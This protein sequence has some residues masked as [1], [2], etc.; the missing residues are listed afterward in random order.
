MKLPQEVYA[1]I[2]SRLLHECRSM[3]SAQKEMQEL[4]AAYNRYVDL[5]RQME[6]CR[7]RMSTIMRLL[8]PKRV[9]DTIRTD[10]AAFLRQTLEM[11]PSLQEPRK[12]LKLWRA[13]REYL[14]VAGNSRVGDVQAFL[15]WLGIKNVTRQAI[16]SALRQHK[17]TFQ[18]S[19]TGRQRYVGLKK[20]RVFP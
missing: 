10:D 2:Q 4:A 20:R 13:V 8:G 3:R 15:E 1:R 14:R 19:T 17:E 11:Y 9:A 12:G 7:H 5:D 18:V 16:E 6:D